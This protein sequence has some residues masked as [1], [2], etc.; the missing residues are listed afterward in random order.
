MREIKFRVWN[1]KEKKWESGGI[2]MDLKGDCEICW[3][4]FG[5]LMERAENVILCQYTGLKDKNDKEIY[6]GDIVRYQILQKN[7]WVKWDG[8]NAKFF[9]CG[10]SNDFDSGSY[11][12]SAFK[13]MEIIGNIWENGDLLNDQNN[14]NN[15][16]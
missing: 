9:A 15:Q 13:Q 1:K 14:A 12:A 7:Y 5:E 8:H 11:R 2:A 16:G 3:T 10:K 4:E 6:E